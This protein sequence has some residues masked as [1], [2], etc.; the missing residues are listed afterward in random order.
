VEDDAEL[1]IVVKTREDLF[2]ALSKRVRELQSYDVPEVIAMP[3]VKG[4]E[5]YLKWIG[6]VT[7]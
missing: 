5:D 3:I 1:L 6:E 2:E 7:Q 4:S